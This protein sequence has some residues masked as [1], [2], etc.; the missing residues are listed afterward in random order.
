M[1]QIG[2]KGMAR[3]DRINSKI[4]VGKMRTNGRMSE[5]ELT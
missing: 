2:E 1:Q 3:N 5:L 4:M